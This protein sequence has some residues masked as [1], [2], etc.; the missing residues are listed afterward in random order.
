MATAI[1][2]QGRPYMPSI[3]INKRKLYTYKQVTDLLTSKRQSMERS[4]QGRKR[5][6]DVKGQKAGRQELKRERKGRLPR[7][8]GA[9]RS[10][11]RGHEERRQNGSKASEAAFV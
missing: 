9:D 10:K 6:R 11:G 3:R 7:R 5:D 4:R 2:P 1:G 8:E